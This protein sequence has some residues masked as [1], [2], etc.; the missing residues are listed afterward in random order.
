LINLELNWNWIGQMEL[1]GIGID[2]MECSE[3]HVLAGC[4]YWLVACIGWSPVLAGSD[5]VIN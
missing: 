2:K 1:S 3:L 4:L 5:L